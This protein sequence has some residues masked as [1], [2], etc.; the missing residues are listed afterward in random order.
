M[1]EKQE[2]LLL[3]AL[4]AASA[5]SEYEKA[6]LEWGK[7]VRANGVTGH[8]IIDLARVDHAAREKQIRE[9]AY[10]AGQ[11][12]NNSAA[13]AAPSWAGASSW[14]VA[15]AALVPSC[16][17]YVRR[18]VMIACAIGLGAV[19]HAGAVQL[20]APHEKAPPRGE[21]V[22]PDHPKQEAHTRRGRKTS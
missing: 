4:D 8:D 18:V 6:L 13:A 16:V 1:T 17:A 14:L 9:A 10:S 7:S 22:R 20:A 11:A 21:L 5:E 15:L 3:R 2:K 19:L 12:G